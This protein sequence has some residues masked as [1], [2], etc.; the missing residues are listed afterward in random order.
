MSGTLGRASDPND[1][2]SFRRNNSLKRLVAFGSTRSLSTILFLGFTL[3]YPNAVLPVLGVS[4]PQYPL[5]RVM[6][7]LARDCCVLL[8]SVGEVHIRPGSSRLPDHRPYG[9]W[10]PCSL[11]AK[12]GFRSYLTR[13]ASSSPLAPLSIRSMV[14]RGF[15]QVRCASM[16]GPAPAWIKRNNNCSEMGRFRSRFESSSAS[17]K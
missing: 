6:N 2:T 14:G 5:E 13:P 3:P 10:R 11:G 17:L 16:K 9:E 8:R 15:Y 12:I 1:L 7:M 4:R